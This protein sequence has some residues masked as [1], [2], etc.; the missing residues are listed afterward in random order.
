MRGNVTEKKL[1]V[2]LFVMVLVSF[3]LAQKETKRMEHL[4][5]GFHSPIGSSLASY[6]TVKSPP[7]SKF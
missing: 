7:A 1:V 4:Y 6:T 5:Y 2:V 3:S